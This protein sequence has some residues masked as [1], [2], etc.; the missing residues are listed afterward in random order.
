MSGS[1]FIDIA[2]FDASKLT[3]SAPRQIKGSNMVTF[4]V[5]YAG[6]DIV[7]KCPPCRAPFGFSFGNQ[8]TKERWETALEV[9]D[10]PEHEQLADALD[11][12]CAFLKAHFRSNMATIFGREGLG[13]DAK[14]AATQEATF[15]AKYDDVMNIVRRKDGKQPLIGIKLPK[16]TDANPLMKLL[17]PTRG[18]YINLEDT[19][20]VAPDKLRKTCIGATVTAVIHV[21]GVLVTTVTP[22]VQLNPKHLL[23]RD[24][25]KTDDEYAIF[26]DEMD[27]GA[28]AKPEVHRGADV[29]PTSPS[30]DEEVEAL[31]D[32]ADSP[33]QAKRAKF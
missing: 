24:V 21:R 33:P 16:V 7:I 3:A 31:F 20:E 27:G 6:K 32:A 28:A 22:S 11:A 30:V 18:V 14:K 2:S 23:V 17:T 1:T 29:A 9:A 5:K 4:D 13:Y 12:I 15:L 25:S 26:E 19:P 8:F 10:T